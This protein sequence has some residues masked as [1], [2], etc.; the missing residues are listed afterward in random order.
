MI[1]R[2]PLILFIMTLA[3]CALMI[4]I[5]I[6]GAGTKLLSTKTG[7]GR[8]IAANYNSCIIVFAVILAA[9]IIVTAVLNARIRKK[10]KTPVTAEVS[11]NEN[12]VY[13]SHF[14]PLPPCEEADASAADVQQALTLPEETGVADLPDTDH[15]SRS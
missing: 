5:R 1:R 10:K 2:L 15:L 7:T 6:G 4:L 9:F 12:S 11:H 14:E 8:F 3:S 13:E